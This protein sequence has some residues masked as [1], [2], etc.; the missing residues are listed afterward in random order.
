MTSS[1]TALPRKSGLPPFVLP[2]GTLEGLKWLG[3]L[4]MTIDHINRFLLAGEQPWM[5][6]LGRLTVPIFAAVLAHN[7]ARPGNLEK[8]V[9]KRTLERLIVFGTIATPTFIAIGGTLGDSAWPLNI[10]FCFA[11][12]VACVWLID[13]DRT[14]ATSS[15]VLVFA[16][17]GFLVEYLWFGVGF[18]IAVWYYSRRPT[19]T[20][21]VFAVL[22]CAGLNLV[23]LS[24]WSLLALP[25][26]WLAQRIDVRVPRMRLVFY[27]Y[28]P[29][30]FAAIWGLQQTTTLRVG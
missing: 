20:A 3:L 25:L 21:A 1:A 27:A 11:T 13:L 4:L 12:V 22:F 28:Y 30:H 16:L 24:F 23:V 18:G 10:M 9:Y 5:N 29:L 6:S 7:L 26:L 19:W 14:W 2:D 17:S 15:M 8:G